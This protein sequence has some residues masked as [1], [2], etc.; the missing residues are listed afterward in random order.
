MKESEYVLYTSDNEYVVEFLLNQLV[1]SKSITEAK[2]FKKSENPHAFKDLL[3]KKF[4]LICSVNT[5][6]E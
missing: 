1:L 2:V 4:D 3:F 5:Y 6:I